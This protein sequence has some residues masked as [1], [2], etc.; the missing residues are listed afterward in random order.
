MTRS[1]SRGSKAKGRFLDLL[2]AG[3]TVTKAAEATG[4]T[5]QTAYKW[6]AADAEFGERWAEAIDAGTEALVSEAHRR[7]VVGVPEPIFYKGAQ[8]GTVQRYSDSMLML[9][10]KSRDP[11]T[12]CDRARTAAIVRRWQREDAER[13]RKSAG[14]G[15]KP[16]V[17]AMLDAVAAWKRAQAATE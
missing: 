14:T 3:V 6:R 4:V 16:E 12:Y 8:V 10:L 7:A 13:E 2:A 11:E 17:L 15:I 9:L 1:N 5:R